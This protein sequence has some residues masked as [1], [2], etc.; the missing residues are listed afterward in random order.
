MTRDQWLNRCAERLREKAGMEPGEAA[1]SAIMLHENQ[2]KDNGRDPAG[3]D[4]PDDAADEEISYMTEDQ[5]DNV[6]E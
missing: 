2:V 4:D 5:L 1:A 6:L 3:W